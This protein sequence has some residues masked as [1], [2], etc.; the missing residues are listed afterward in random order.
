MAQSTPINPAA[1]IHP[2]AIEVSDFTN[3]VLLVIFM[4]GYTTGVPP[5][6]STGKFIFNSAPLGRIIMYMTV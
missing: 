1:Q 6:I 5:D 4:T 2:V 3:A